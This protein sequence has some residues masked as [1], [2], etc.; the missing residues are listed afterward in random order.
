MIPPRQFYTHVI[1]PVLRVMAEHDPRFDSLAARR[2]LLGTAV[3]ESRLAAIAQYGS[4]PALSFFQIEPSTHT[5]IRRWAHE[6]GLDSVLDEFVAEWTSSEGQLASNAAYAC[7]VARLIYFRI[8][9]PLPAAGDLP[10]L[11]RYWKQYYNTRL[12]KGSAVKWERTYRRY[13]ME[14]IP[15]GE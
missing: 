14:A 2:L 1:A 10:G 3:E 11:G 13:C 4:G 5:D 12:G 8:P 6:R 15:D 7:A 9:E